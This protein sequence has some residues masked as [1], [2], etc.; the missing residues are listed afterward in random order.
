M[1]NTSLQTAYPQ[2]LIKLQLITQNIVV[3]EDCLQHACEKALLHW[4]KSL[5]DNPV[6]WLVTVGRNAFVDFVR[7]ENKSISIES[8]KEQ[9]I[10]PDLSEQALLLSYND[11]LLRL[12]FTCCH[13][14][15]N[16][17]TQ[18]VLSL[19]H[20]LGLSSKQIASAL[21][22]PKK[23]IEQ[24]LTRAKKKIL[25]NNITYEIPKASQLKERLDGVL[26]T[27]YLLFN[28]GYLTTEDSSFISEQLCKEAIRLCRLLHHCLSGEAEIIGLLALLLHLDARLKARI[29]NNGEMILLAEQNREKWEQIKI[30][31]ANQ[32]VEKSLLLGGGTSYAIQAAIASLHNNAKSYKETDWQQIYQLYL[33]LNQIENN[34]VVGLNAWVAYAQYGNFQQAIEKIKLL[35]KPLKN[36]RHYHSALAGLYFEKSYYLE[37][38][39]YYLLAIDKTDSAAEKRFI[40]QRIQEC[41]SK[42]N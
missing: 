10:L 41:D 31:E 37:A 4:Q 36:Y 12:V 34:P 33:K 38:K 27:I 16:F 6:A 21:V 26:K 14:A 24:R 15:L 11:D 32:L 1:L 2:A 7:K 22:I 28:E 30:Q 17:E 35:A 25:V 8:I 3:A 9:S 23:T 42:I 5:P 39:D 29:N 13:P 19:K 18:V 20:V 40:Q